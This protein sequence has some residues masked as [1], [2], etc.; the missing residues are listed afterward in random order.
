M[1]EEWCEGVIKNSELGPVQ[2]TYPSCS[3]GKVKTDKPQSLLLEKIAVLLQKDFVK[4]SSVDLRGLSKVRSVSLFYFLHA[5][6]KLMLWCHCRN[7]IA[8]CLFH[9]FDIA[10]I[11]FY[12]HYQYAILNRLL[13][14]NACSVQEY[15]CDT[16]LCVVSPSFDRLRLG[17]SFLLFC[18]WSKRC[19]IKVS[20]ILTWDYYTNYYICVAWF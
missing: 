19:T 7:T 8:F 15:P 5:P 3:S 17:L 6:L 12:S 4:G 2:M 10:W 16:V 14:L 18:G 13:L 9:S 20:I 11:V 1:L